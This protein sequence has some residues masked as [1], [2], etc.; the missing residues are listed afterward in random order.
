MAG[1][2]LAHAAAVEPLEDVVPRGRRNR[3]AIV[4][5][6]EDNELVA[7]LRSQTDAAVRAVILARVLEQILHNQSDE[8]FFARDEKIRWKIRLQF[9]M[10]SSGSALKSS[11]HSSINCERFTVPN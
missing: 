10:E 1:D 2:V 11:T 8:T 5:D 9:Y 3:P 6:C 7:L 4:L